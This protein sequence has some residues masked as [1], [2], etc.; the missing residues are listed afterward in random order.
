MVRENLFRV[1]GHG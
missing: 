1:Y